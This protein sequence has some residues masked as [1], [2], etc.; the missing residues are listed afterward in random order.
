MFSKIFVF[1]RLSPGHSLMDGF[2]FDRINGI[3]TTK[4]TTKSFE[5]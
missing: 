2:A 4:E 5:F 1:R 3:Y